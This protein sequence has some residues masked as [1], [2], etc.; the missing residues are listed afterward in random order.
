MEDEKIIKLYWARD[1]N[2]VRETAKKYGKLC[3]FVAENILADQEEVE[4]CYFI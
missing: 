3:F 4:E 1:E 2:A